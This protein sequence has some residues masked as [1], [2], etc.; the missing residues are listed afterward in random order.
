MHLF[1]SM[2]PFVC[3]RHADCIHTVFN[4]IYMG[5]S[6]IHM[7]DA[8]TGRVRSSQRLFTTQSSPTLLTPLKVVMSPTQP[9]RRTI[10]GPLCPAPVGDD[11]HCLLGL[12]Q[13]VILSCMC[14]TQYRILSICVFFVPLLCHATP[15]QTCAPCLVT[16]DSV[17][18]ANCAICLLDYGKIRL[19]AKSLSSDICMSTCALH[20]HCSHCL[21]FRYAHLLAL[22]FLVLV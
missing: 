19:L 5:P 6:K 22:C 10:P 17:L 21:H 13:I 20:S 1:V 9:S 16:L 8:S 4:L 11:K 14:S 7:Y 18:K 15:T 12:L 3:S 2:H